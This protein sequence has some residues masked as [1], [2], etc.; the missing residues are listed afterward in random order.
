MHYGQA[1]RFSAQVPEGDIDRADGAHRRSATAGLDR[2]PV[3]LRPQIL[4]FESAGAFEDRAKQ[5]VHHGHHRLATVVAERESFSAQSVLGED[6]NN[7]VVAVC[8]APHS[9]R[10][11]RPQR[12]RNRQR[13]NLG[14]LHETSNVTRRT[15]VH[16]SSTISSMRI[17]LALTLFTALGWCAPKTETGEI[18]G[19]RFRIDVPEQWNGSLVMYC[20][21]YRP[22]AGKFANPK[23]NPTLD[24]FLKEGYPVVQAG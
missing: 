1:R 24:V 3:H 18:N 4:R 16:P 2:L 19:A 10:H 14:D 17:L 11:R 22:V 13:F 23:P 6:A 21:G 15:G 20:H 12:D 8:D 5:R 7:Q 9:I